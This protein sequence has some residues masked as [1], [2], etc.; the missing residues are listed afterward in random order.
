MKFNYNRCIL[1]EPKV[2]VDLIVK[3]S[4]SSGKHSV[5]IFDQIGITKVVWKD[6]T[7]NKVY[8]AFIAK[9]PAKY[10]DNIGEE[11][12]YLFVI[13]ACTTTSKAPLQPP[14]LFNDDEDTG[15]FEPPWQRT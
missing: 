8:P 7:S 13:R 11:D 4:K 6:L 9:Y 5:C 12:G 10:T 14:Q 15:M 1:P 3:D 2:H